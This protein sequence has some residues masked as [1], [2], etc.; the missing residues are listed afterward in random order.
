MISILILFLYFS[1]ITQVIDHLLAYF[2][3][4]LDYLVVNFTTFQL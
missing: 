2:S 4:L 3:Y 1:L